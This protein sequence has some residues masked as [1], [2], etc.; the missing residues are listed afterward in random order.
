MSCCGFLYRDCFAVSFKRQF[1]P[2]LET[3]NLPP[4]QHT[5]IDSVY[6]P[7]VSKVESEYKR[8]A[9]AFKILTNIIIIGGVVITALI[10]LNQVFVGDLNDPLFWITWGL[11]LLT[12]IASKMLYSY[13]F[14]KKYLVKGDF[15]VRLRSEGLLFL[16]NSGVYEALDANSGFKLFVSRTEDLHRRSTGNS[17]MLEFN[18][19]IEIVGTAPMDEESQPV[20]RSR[21]GA[22]GGAVLA[23]GGAILTSMTRLHNDSD[24]EF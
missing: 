12:T 1:K 3:K 17:A 8:A 23:S 21:M 9:Y 4:D 22:S 18:D 10:S 16:Q 20:M 5:Y 2:I 24:D 11:S 19:T 13:S 7:T 14:D 6:I 15:M